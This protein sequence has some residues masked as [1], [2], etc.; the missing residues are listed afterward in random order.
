MLRFLLFL[1]GLALVLIGVLA[2][3]C[4]L[5]FTPGLFGTG[6]FEGSGMFPIWAAGMVTGALGLWLGIWA[7][8]LCC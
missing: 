4:S 2:G 6:E 8:D 1:L 7:L 3:G 5:L